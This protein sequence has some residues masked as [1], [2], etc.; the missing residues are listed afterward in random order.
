LALGGTAL[1]ASFVPSARHRAAVVGRG[2]A[3]LRLA[4][5]WRET[6]ALDLTATIDERSTPDAL[7]DAL[8]SAR[9]ELLG[10]AHAASSAAVLLPAIRAGVRGLYLHASA[11]HSAERLDAMAD[12]CRR[13]AVAVACDVG[14]AAQAATLGELIAAGELGRVTEIR[15]AATVA[16]G[17]ESLHVAA[18]RLLTLLAALAEPPASCHA[19]LYL[20][21]RPVADE[22]ARRTALQRPG[23]AAAMHAVYRLANGGA[24]HLDIAGGGRT[25]QFELAVSGT[26]A[27]ASIGNGTAARRRLG[28]DCSPSRLSHPWQPLTEGEPL[29]AAEFVARD[30]I[31]AVGSGR[32]ATFHLEYARTATAMLAAAVASQACEKEVAFG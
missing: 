29:G 24:V 2:P 28:R 9:P 6:A 23:A 15:A 21:G 26:K 18:H 1:A 14:P 22:A 27:H 17:D 25:S 20:E 13:R 11:T 4:D 19:R 10:V 5:E 32:G 8:R 31:E 3:A 7:L 30:L 12:L 16:R